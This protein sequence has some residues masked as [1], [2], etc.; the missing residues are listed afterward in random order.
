MDAPIRTPA[1]RRMGAALLVLAGL[2]VAGCSDGGGDAFVAP[3]P[4][5]PAP[6]PMGAA[7]F[8]AGFGTSFAANRDSD[9]RNPAENDIV[10]INLTTDPLEVP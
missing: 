7:R 10:A 4:P 5:P 3:P 9:P 8:G 6:A 1:L 2:Q